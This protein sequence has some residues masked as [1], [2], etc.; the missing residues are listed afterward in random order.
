MV[1]EHGSGQA[2]GHADD[3]Q[4][5]R[6]VEHVGDDRQQDAERAPA[7]AGGEAQHTGD[8]EDDRRQE[9]KQRA[10]GGVHDGSDEVLAAEQTGHVLERRS[11]S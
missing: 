5:A 1:A 11:G 8:D 3:K 4:L 10:R 7:R 2:R 6:R 9:A